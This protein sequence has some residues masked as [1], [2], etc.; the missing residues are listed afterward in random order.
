MARQPC[1]GCGKQVSIAG[2]IA[3][4]WTMEKDTTGGIELELADG[5]EFFLCF[6]CIERL[7]DDRDATADDVAALPDAE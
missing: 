7:P 6:D 2:G 5:S 3:N 4:L 1:D